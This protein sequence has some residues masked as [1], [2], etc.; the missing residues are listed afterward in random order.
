M[1]DKTKKLLT[2]VLAVL[3]IAAGGLAWTLSQRNDTATSKTNQSPAASTAKTTKQNTEPVAY[4][5]QEGKNAL[6]LLEQNAT[7]VTK[8]SAYGK[9]VDTI[10]GVQGGTDGKY[11]AFYVND[12][13]AQVGAADYATKATD[14]IEWKFE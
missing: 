3:V 10:N 14:K 1:G 5:G 7:I 11:W 12:Q 4:A 13:L 6:E 9:Y 2:I 8:D